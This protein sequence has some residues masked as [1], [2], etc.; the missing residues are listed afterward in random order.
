MAMWPP[1]SGSNGSR[2]NTP[3]KKFSVMRKLRNSVHAPCCTASPPSRLA[4]TTLIGPFGSRGWPARACHRFGTRFGMFVMAVP[5]PEN[6]WPVNVTDCPTEST[7]P[8]VTVVGT[9]GGSF[10]P[11]PSAATVDT[12]PLIVMSSTACRL[13]GTRV[14]CAVCAVPA[15]S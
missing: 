8:Y 12:G 15:R 13:A 10:Q 1:S 4:P 6:S 3:T 14:T 11:T 2:L 5:M 7:G 9:F